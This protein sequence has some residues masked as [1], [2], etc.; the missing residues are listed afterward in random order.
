LGTLPKF[1]YGL[2]SKLRI[3]TYLHLQQIFQS[4]NQFDPAKGL[5]FF[6]GCLD[7]SVLVEFPFQPG[8]VVS[9]LVWRS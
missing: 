3:G 7:S 2:A 1:L 9:A 6:K 5:T 4:P 8:I